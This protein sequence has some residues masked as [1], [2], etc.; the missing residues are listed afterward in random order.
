MKL[1]QLS[2]IAGGLMAAALASAALPSASS[3]QTNPGFNART[4]N[5]NNLSPIT[6]VDSCPEPEAEE[7]IGLPDYYYNEGTLFLPDHPR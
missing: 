1:P 2:S 6:I 4:R 5:F 3:A 7:C